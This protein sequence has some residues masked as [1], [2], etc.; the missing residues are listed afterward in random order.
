[1]IPAGPWCSSTSR[2]RSEVPRRRGALG[3]AAAGDHRLIQLIRGEDMTKGVAGVLQ[4]IVDDSYGVLGADLTCRWCGATVQRETHEPH[5][6]SCLIDSAEQ[7]L[8]L[9]ADD[10]DNLI[11]IKRTYER[12]LVQMEHMREQIASLKGERDAAE[13]ELTSRVDEDAAQRVRDEGAGQLLP[14]PRITR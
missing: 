5:H 1:M 6:R 11:D 3:G 13:A 14:I 7:A 9:P 4:A 8:R 12:K 10:I 2:S